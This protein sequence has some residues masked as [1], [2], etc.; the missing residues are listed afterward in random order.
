MKNKFNK[1]IK[2]IKL[3]IIVL[4]ILGLSLFAVIGVV[5]GIV[6]LSV[7]NKII[8]P[9]EAATLES[10][11]ILVLG[12]GVWDG[13]RPSHMLEDRLLEG[14]RLYE[15]G[16]SK[17]LLMSGDHGNK[18]YDEVNVMKSFAMDRGIESGN[19]FMD[20]AGFSTYES[21]YR[22]RD[23]FQA[24]KVVIVTQ[25]YHLYRALYIGKKLGLDVYGVPSN[26]RDYAGQPYRD[27][28]EVLARVKDF[29]N[30]I[31]KPQPTYLG[32]VIPVSGNGNQTND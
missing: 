32:E 11:C 26:L 30:A 20:H 24:K 13:G 2:T 15:L 14:I 10:D 17:K 22:A 29:I 31:I 23:I 4:T 18:E 25:Q 28:R 6:I 16:A 21:I 3:F 27:A 1:Y 9:Q 12:A 5:N 8:T 19:I 7:K